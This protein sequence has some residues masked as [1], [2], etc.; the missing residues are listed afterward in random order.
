MKENHVM[1][2]VVFLLLSSCCGRNTAEKIKEDSKKI[3][4]GGKWETFVLGDMDHDGVIDTAFVY[5]S[6]YYGT[7]DS[8]MPELTMFDSCVN[9]HC[10]NKIKFSSALPG[11]SVENT[12]W[13]SVEAIEDLDEDGISEFIFQTNWFIGSHVT[14][15][16][17]SFNKKN[18]KW[19]V[20]AENRLYQQDSYQDRIKKIDKEK[21]RFKI[22]Y[23]DTIDDHDIRNKEVVVEIRK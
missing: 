16:I 8:E 1:L 3:F 17:Y 6:A 15:Q 12:L 9:Q 23:M 10:Y 21:F 11:I 18:G 20:L 4:N 7:I 22:E 14:I 13:G 19:L 5:T 2:Y